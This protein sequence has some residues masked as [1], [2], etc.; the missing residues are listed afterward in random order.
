M[1]I[2][3]S[4]AEEREVCEVLTFIDL[5]KMK[6]LKV[7]VDTGNGMA[8]LFM[9]FF[10]E[11]LPWKVE[12]LFYKLDGTFPNHVPSPI[13]EKNR[14]D[15]KD[16][17]LETGADLGLVF[18]GDGDRVYLLDEKGK[19]LSG[20]VMT[21]I[22]AQSLL[23]KHPGGSIL[24]NAVVGRIVPEVISKEGGKPIR[25]KVGHTL[26]KEAMRKE[27]GLFCGEHSGHYYF[28][29]F[30]YAD[31]AIIAALLVTELMS[32]KDVKLSTLREEFDK[33]PSTLQKGELNFSVDEKEVVMKE[34]ES[35]YKKEA[36]KIDWLDGLSLWFDNYWVNIRPSN[37][38]SLLR[39]NLEA[40]KPDIFE[41]K[42]KEF[43]S[44]IKGMGGVLKE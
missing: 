3:R 7:V 38:E 36:K 6:P 31:S 9:P 43:V 4:S 22:I 26:I 28:K 37:T 15:C 33:Y 30:F 29:K 25:V 44:K 14:K 19:T 13:E 27:D 16:K 18:D 12:R 40:D 34:L 17:I 41:Q 1:A 23:K 42:V 20:T 10:E 11:K 2:I 24:Y 32:E 5:A 35:E 21:A 8:G 39:L